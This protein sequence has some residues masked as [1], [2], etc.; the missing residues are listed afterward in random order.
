M[1]SLA[2]CDWQTDVA[3]DAIKKKI[4]RTKER[5]LENVD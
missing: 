2:T 4:F 5:L 3:S 1:L